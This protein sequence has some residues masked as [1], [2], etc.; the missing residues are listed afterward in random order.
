MTLTRPRLAWLAGALILAG[1]AVWFW[2]GRAPSA[3]QMLSWMPEGE[4]AVLYVDFA[5]L[6]R[7]GLLDRLAGDVAVAEDDYKAFIGATG[8]DFRRDLDAALVKFRSDATLFVLA[9]NFDERRLENYAAA[10]GGRCVN[11]LCSLPAA[12]PGKKISFVKLGRNVLAMAAAE[13]PMAA[14]LIATTNATPAPPA[15]MSSVWLM[16]PRERLRST[17][18]LPAGM[19]AFLEA[20]SGAERAVFL[21]RPSGAGV[22]VVLEA[23]CSSNAVASRVAGRLTKATSLLKSLLARE[24]KEPARDDLSGILT[25]GTFRADQAVVRGF[26]PAPRE[27]LEKLTGQ[28]PE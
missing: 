27:F 8:F 6:R 23:P 28:A 21:L 11:G 10:Q 15:P 17:A 13:D 25:A 12:T 24:G 18:G 26:W 2:L 5:L 16:V 9:G 20:M 3:S 22:D 4:G 7:T 19:S 1:A 14:G